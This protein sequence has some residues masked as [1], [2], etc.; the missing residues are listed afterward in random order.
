MK[1]VIYIVII[2]GLAAVVGAIVVGKKSFDGTVTDNAYETG[3]K[4]DSVQKEREESGIQLEILSEPLFAGKNA[5]S[6]RISGPKNTVYNAKQVSAKLIRPSTSSD[7]MQVLLTGTGDGIFKSDVS[8][9]S[10]GHWTISVTVPYNG[11]DLVFEKQVYPG[12]VA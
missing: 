5:L 11:R 12:I 9:P 3:L 7:D 4:W 6:V 10:Y 2:F 1:A 8:F